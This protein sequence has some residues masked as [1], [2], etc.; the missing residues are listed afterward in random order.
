MLGVEQCPSIKANAPLPASR[1]LRRT[2]TPLYLPSY[3]RDTPLG[4]GQVAIDGL[5]IRNDRCRAVRGPLACWSEAQEAP[6]LL[7]EES[8]D[9]APERT[10]NT[11]WF[12]SL[13][14]STRAA[15]GSS[16][17]RCCHG[18]FRL[19]SISCSRVTFQQYFIIS[20]FVRGTARRW[21][22]CT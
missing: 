7:V 13:A 8:F 18:I 6:S 22:C 14:R 4:G 11:A 19:N 5:V 16:V 20:S 10:M 1:T 17:Q 9:V 15:F 21:R 12:L 3:H 2:K